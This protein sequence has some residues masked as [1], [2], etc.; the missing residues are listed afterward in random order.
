MTLSLRRTTL[1]G[2]TREAR[3]N[4]LSI[5]FSDQELELLQDY[6][7]EQTI[8]VSAAIRQLALTN[9]LIKK[10]REKKKAS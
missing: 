6:A 10:E 7:E 9:P 2:V 8:S 1:G 3:P 4:P 5:R